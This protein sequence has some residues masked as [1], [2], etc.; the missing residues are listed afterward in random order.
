MEAMKNKDALDNYLT[1]L[2]SILDD[3]NLGTKPGQIYNMDETGIPLDH[4]SPCVL[5]K[6]GQKKLDIAPQET[7]LRLL[8]LS[9]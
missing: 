4:R 9:A 7:S 6:K 3:Y 2:K 1:L 5:V 8:L